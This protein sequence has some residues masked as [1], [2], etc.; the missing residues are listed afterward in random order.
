MLFKIRV[1]VIEGRRR[2]VST[3]TVF[4]PIF[5]NETAKF[6]TVVDF[7]SEGFA[8]QTP[9]FRL[10]NLRF[11]FLEGSILFRD[12]NTERICL[13]ASVLKVRLFSKVVINSENLSP[14]RIGKLPSKGYGAT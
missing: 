14:L 9:I 13:K 11:R 12:N 1:S 4:N 2:S 5:A 3:T 7:P 6:I 10:L 8:E